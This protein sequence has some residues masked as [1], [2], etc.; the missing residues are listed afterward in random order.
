MNDKALTDLARRDAAHL[1]HG[2]TNLVQH[3]RTGPKVI[4]RGKGIYIYDEQGREYIEA[5]AGMWCASFGFS[6]PE[7]V[8]AA[9]RQLRALPYYHT[10]TSRSVT[11][12]IELAER[13]SKLVPVENNHIYLAVSGSEANDFLVKFLWQYHNAIGKPR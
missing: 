12:A 2:Y 8:E 6:E 5:A 10:M 9:V 11:P 1:V 13:L 3:E 4:T 7:L